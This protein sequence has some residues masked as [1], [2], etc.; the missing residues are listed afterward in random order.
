MKA[1]RFHELGGPEVLQYE[2][3][4]DPTP[5]PGQ[6]LLK[7]EAG[8]LNFSDIAKRAGRYL[9]PTPLP[10]TPGSEAAGD[11]VARIAVGDRVTGIFPARSGAGGDRRRRVRRLPRQR[12]RRHV[13]R[14]DEGP[15]PIR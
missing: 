1:V 13:S 6:L 8:G 10:F 2:D 9:E 11:G 4:P 12:W 5:S 14:R 15:D 7:V 3:A